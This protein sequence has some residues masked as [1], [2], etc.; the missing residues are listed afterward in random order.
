M[1]KTLD[2]PP[3]AVAA[4]RSCYLCTREGQQV[5]SGLRDIWLGV[6]GTWSRRRCA[7]C[8]LAWLDPRPHREE[9]W[10]LYGHGYYT[11]S[12]PPDGPADT[13]GVVRRI[14]KRAIRTDDPT[15]AADEAPASRAERL[16]VGGLRA[17]T[18]VRDIA[19]GSSMWVDQ[20]PGAL[21]D[22]GCGNGE[23]L[24]RMRGRGWAVKGVEPDPTSAAFAT[25][26]HGLDVISGTVED[27]GLQ[28]DAFDVVTMS[29]VIEHVHDPIEVLKEC[30]RLLKPGGRLIV[31]TPN[32]QSL[33]RVVFRSRW[34]GWDVP[35][36]LYAFSRRSLRACAARA[37]LEVDELRTTSRSTFRQLPSTP[38][39]IRMQS[40][41]GKRD[42]ARI[43]TLLFWLLESAMGRA[44]PCGE[45][46][47][48]IARRPA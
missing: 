19:A 4:A 45:E 12:L 38:R 35:R 39:F 8:G 28:R 33:G 43:R 21:L 18:S 42:R 23:F 41:T 47:L 7:G 25:T 5:S 14:V 32:R 1:S 40:D 30:K 20:P 31:V 2:A 37:G 29:H 27:A 3:I 16:A 24:V 48:L 44:I 22:V 34:H 6:T 46:I 13:P 10:K 36:H 15:R 26:H 17:L 11:H 9:L